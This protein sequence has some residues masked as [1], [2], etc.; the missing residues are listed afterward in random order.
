MATSF[1][2][3]GQDQNYSSILGG[4]FDT[5]VNYGRSYLPQAETATQ[6]ATIPQANSPSPGAPAWLKPVLIGVGVLVAVVVVIPL[7]GRK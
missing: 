7:L 5:A 4:L 1:E 6:A 3:P 2:D